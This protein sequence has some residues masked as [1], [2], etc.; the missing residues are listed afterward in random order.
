MVFVPKE[1]EKENPMYVQKVWKDVKQGDLKKERPLMR[2][3][4][5]EICIRHRHLFTS[6]SFNTSEVEKS[7]KNSNKKHKK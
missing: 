4:M 3:L 6:H 5:N 1:Q 7:G 2:A